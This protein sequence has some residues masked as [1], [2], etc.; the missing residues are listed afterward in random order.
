MLRCAKCVIPQTRPDTAF[1]GGVCSA[2]LSYEKRPEIDWKT[3]KA[4]LLALLDKHNGKVIVPSSGGK[5]S[6]Y[7]A[8]TLKELGADVTAVTAT[9][10]Y[11]TDVGRA[12]LDNLARHVRT[13]EVSPNRE[14]RKK[15]NR[16]GLQLVGDISHPEHMG[17]FSTPFRMA[18]A[19]SIPLMFYG[20]SPQAQYGGP[21]G[22]EEARTMT[23]R[24]VSEFGGFNGLRPQDFVGMDDITECQMADYMLPSDGDME[25]VG[26]EAHFLGQYI[27]WDSFRNADVSI[28]AGFTARLPYQGCYWPAENLDNAQTGIHDYFGFLKFGYGRFAA[29]VSVDVRKGLITRD[30][31][32]ALVE[33]RD[34]LFPTTYMGVPLARVLKDIG[35]SSDEFIGLCNQF[36]NRDI[37]RGDVTWGQRP[38]LMVESVDVA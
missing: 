1:V 3:R 21:L 26:V 8:I 14:V 13:I 35:M 30:E 5:D 18:V 22:S 33:A 32:M 12:N 38:E 16:L 23:R 2:C 34:G 37:F 29:Q 31:A 4:E 27:P 11:L 7:Q 19:L 20:E 36:L 10:C 17:I 9:T 24:W 15:L 6:T 28:M 25:R